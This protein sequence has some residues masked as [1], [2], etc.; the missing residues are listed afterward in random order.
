MQPNPRTGTEKTSRSCFSSRP[1]WP[2]FSS[3][4]PARGGRGGAAQVP[5]PS[6][7]SGF[8]RE[9]DSGKAQPTALINVGT[10]CLVFSWAD[11]H[12]SR[13]GYR[14]AT[15]CSSLR[16]GD[17][18]CFLSNWLSRSLGSQAWSSLL[19]AGSRFQAGALEPAQ[20]GCQQT[21]LLAGG[22]A[23]PQTGHPSL[24]CRRVP[25]GP[26]PLCCSSAARP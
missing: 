1:S 5:P 10:T 4:V 7:I 23:A 17:D 13:G 12:G 9:E 18:G 21:S 11:D 2:Q 15:A 6:P 24:N 16:L 26:L 8:G 19:R 20:A 3:P 14:P 25:A 22:K